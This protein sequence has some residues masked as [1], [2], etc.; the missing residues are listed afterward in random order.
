MYAIRS[1]YGQA[2]QR[3]E[4]DA[5]RDRLSKLEKDIAELSSERDAMAARWQAEK[6]KIDELRAVKQRIEELK[7]EESK[8]ERERNNFV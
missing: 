5:S 3:E 2:L 4:D 7:I 1:Y 6:S 8:W